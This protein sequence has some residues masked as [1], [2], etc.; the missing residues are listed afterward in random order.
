[1][2]A[3]N[4]QLIQCWQAFLDERG[5]PERPWF[6]NMIYAPGA[7]TGYGVKT[8]PAIRESIEE[9]KWKQADAG[10]IQAAGAIQQS[11]EQIEKAAQQLDAL[12]T[13]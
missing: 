11:A 4:H 2:D 3:L 5:L 12:A 10:I 6:K 1:M 13:D 8:L 9:K 7:Y